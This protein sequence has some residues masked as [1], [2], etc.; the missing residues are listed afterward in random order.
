M[1]LSF[2]GKEAEEILVALDERG[3]NTTALRKARS[4]QQPRQRPLVDLELLSKPPQLAT[5]PQRK[6]T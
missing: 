4:D 2:K 1:E 3:V 5:P 6:E